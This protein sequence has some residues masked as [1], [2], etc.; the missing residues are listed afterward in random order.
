M[1]FFLLS[2]SVIWKS[3]ELSTAHYFSLCNVWGHFPNFKLLH[4]IPY[5]ENFP[6]YHSLNVSVFSSVTNNSR[7]LSLLAQLE[8][9]N[10]EC[11]VEAD[12]ARY[13][14]SK[15]LHLTQSQGKY[16]RCSLIEVCACMCI[17]GFHIHSV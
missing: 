7:I 13:I 10:A 17:I 6:S 8:K 11:L 5:S 12:T 4:F 9:I 16:Y 2:F 1:L 15:I 14:T 3:K